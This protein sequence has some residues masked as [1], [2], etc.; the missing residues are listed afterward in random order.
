VSTNWVF[1]FEGYIVFWH[2]DV[3]QEPRRMDM[4]DIVLIQPRDPMLDTQMYDTLVMASLE[5]PPIGLCYLATVLRDLGYSVELIDFNIVP[6]VAERERTIEQLISWRPRIVGIS[7]MTPTYP[8]AVKISKQV[9]K[10]LGKRTKILMGGYHATALPEECLRTFAADIVVKG[11]GEVLAGT[12]NRP[13]MG[14]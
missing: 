6:D 11:E 5:M 7:T 8:G 13:G 12:Q 2:S 9:R 4:K 3:I 14:G 1:V 10:S